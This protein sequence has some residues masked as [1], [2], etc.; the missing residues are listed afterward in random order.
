M[1]YGRYKNYTIDAETGLPQ[2]PSH[3]F[4]R[5]RPDNVGDSAPRIVIVRRISYTTGFWKWKK[6]KEKHRETSWYSWVFNGLERANIDYA[7][8]EVMRKYET[9]LIN[10]KGRNY[11]GDYPPNSLD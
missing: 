2:L 3:L 8:H 10:D 7:A 9:S 11:L 4:W 5:I 1:G 6:T